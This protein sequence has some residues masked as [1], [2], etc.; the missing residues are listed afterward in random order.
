MVWYRRILI[1]G[2]DL[3]SSKNLIKILKEK[4]KV[5]CECDVDLIVCWCEL[6]EILFIRLISTVTTLRSL[7]NV[8]K[9]PH[10]IHIRCSMIWTREIS[11]NF[12]II[13]QYTEKQCHWSCCLR[14]WIHKAGW[15]RYDVFISGFSPSRISGIVREI[16]CFNCVGNIRR[17]YVQCSQVKRGGLWN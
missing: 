9:N 8:N 16:K 14:Q 6:N 2:L 11:N 13:Y 15:L 4:S 10:H 3:P 7:C 17:F 1:Y 5:L 12:Y